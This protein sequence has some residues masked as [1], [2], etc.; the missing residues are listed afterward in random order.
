MALWLSPPVARPTSRLDSTAAVTAAMSAVRQTA[1]SS[2]TCDCPILVVVVTTTRLSESASSRRKTQHQR[3][4]TTGT[5]EGNQFPFAD[6]KELCNRRGHPGRF[7]L[8]HTSIA[9]RTPPPTAKDLSEI[10]KQAAGSA[11]GSMSA[12]FQPR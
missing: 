2:S 10:S 11:R 9:S 6:T 4:L 8:S 3:G 1:G 5:G 7:P 12:I